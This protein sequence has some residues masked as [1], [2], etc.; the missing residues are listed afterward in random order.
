MDPPFNSGEF[1]QFCQQW[2]LDHIT[3]SPNHPQSDGQAERTV[4]TVKQKMA[5]CKE[6]KQD[7]RQALLQMRTTPISKDLPSPFEILRG[8]T[9][10]TITGKQEEKLIDN[11]QIRNALIEHQFKITEHYNRR[12]GVKHLSPLQE[13]DNVLIQ[14]KDGNWEPATI[15]Q[16]GPEPRS[17][18]CA[19][20]AGKVFRRNR[21]H[22]QPTGMP[23]TSTSEQ[24][25]QQTS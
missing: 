23:N 25:K 15:K 6:D 11:T 10:I 18:L 2:N 13:N 12:H 19:T 17:Y 22:I 1:K 20:L 5:R 21:K 3:S 4:Q 7:F 8:R 9:G 14:H 16:V 24:R